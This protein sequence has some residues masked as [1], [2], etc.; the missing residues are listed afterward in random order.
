M[1]LPSEGGAAEGELRV[2]LAHI[3]DRRRFLPNDPQ[4]NDPVQEFV[5]A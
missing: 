2:R 3:H 4:G 1:R 5:V